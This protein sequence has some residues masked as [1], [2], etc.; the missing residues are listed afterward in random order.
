MGDEKRLRIDAHAHLVATD[1]EKHKS[2]V[3]ADK[4][5]GFGFKLL[6]RILGVG[7]D[8]SDEEFDIAYA[9]RLA[10]QV[11]E[12]QY[13]DKVVL[14]AMEGLYDTN[15]NPDPRTEAFVSN[16]WTIEVCRRHPD[17]FLFGAA[18]HPARPDA[19]DEL[20]KC[21]EAGAVCVK[22]VP[23]SQNIDPSDIRYEKFY[24][25]MKEHGL[26]LTSHT[27][28]EHTI[29][30][31]DQTLG[32]PER[33]RLPLEVGLKVVAGHAGTSGFFHRIEYFPNFVRLVNEFDNLYGDTSAIT[34]LYRGPYLKRLLTTPVVKERL[35]QGTD[36]PVPPQ[37][38]SWPFALG[39]IK[40]I[41]LQFHK[42]P[43]DQDIIA[44]K[45]V[46]F[47][48]EHFLRGHNVFLG[49]RDT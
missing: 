31:T 42:N 9:D 40:S 8:A 45:A 38:I 32:D 35:I 49:H 4:R 14:F 16:D 29:F 18:I 22:W 25:R 2:F 47:P 33:L 23:P 30:V 43:F 11:R 48:E 39:P 10:R 20:D 46:G 17:V 26:V 19:Q 34:S 36:Y 21:A 5:K 12:A 1:R 13:T 15:G 27:G 44:K 41:K 7:P 37:T 3:S 28:Y 24:M 6:R